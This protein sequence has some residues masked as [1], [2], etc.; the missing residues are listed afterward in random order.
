MIRRLMWQRSLQ[1]DEV[2][3]GIHL[4]C[5]NED[6]VKNAPGAKTAPGTAVLGVLFAF[7]IVRA[8]LKLAICPS[9]RLA[10]TESNA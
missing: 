1:N 3:Y 2:S 9:Y 7:C 5:A 4:D 10:I 8:Y 6:V